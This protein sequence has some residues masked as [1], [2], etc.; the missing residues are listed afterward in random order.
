MKM[1]T[2]LIVFVFVCSL[3]LLSGCSLLQ[4]PGQLIGGTFDILGK[5]LG[6]ASKLPMPPP[7]IF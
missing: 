2:C 1:R 6:L 5:L 4:I 3:S 7:G